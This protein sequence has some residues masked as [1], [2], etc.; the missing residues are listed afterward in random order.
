MGPTEET[1]QFTY[2]NVGFTIICFPNGMD[3][4]LDGS[5]QKGGVLMPPGRVG[6][7]TKQ[8]SIQGGLTM[9]LYPLKSI[10]AQKGAYKFEPE[11][12][13]KKGCKCY[14]LFQY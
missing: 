3:I 1:A 11:A 8:D 7:C 10:S 2:R 14:N 12:V 13:E 9:K 5:F 6:K 4:L